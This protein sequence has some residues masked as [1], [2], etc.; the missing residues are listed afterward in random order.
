RQRPLLLLL[1]NCEHVLSSVTVFAS[2]LR[3]KASRCKLLVTSREPLRIPS[4]HV[5]VLNSL[6]VPEDATQLTA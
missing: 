2:K 6:T 1:D 3:T 4:E 5:Y